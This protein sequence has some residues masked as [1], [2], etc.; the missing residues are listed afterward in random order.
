M[1]RPAARSISARRC[2]AP[3]PTRSR[4]KT[5]S[6][7]WQLA[8]EHINNGDPL[9]KKIAPKVTKGLLGK[10]VNLLVADSAAKPNDAVQEQQT[11]IN[12]NKIVAMTGST[13]IGGR[14]GAQQVRRAREDALSGGDLR[15]QRHHRQGLRALLLPPV[16]LR[17]DR[18]Q[19]DRP[20]AAQDLRQEQEGGVHDAGLHLRPHRHQVGERL[21]DRERRLD[22]GDQPDLAARH[23]GLQPVPDQHRQFRRRVHCQR[24]LGPRRGAVDP[25]GQ[26]VRPHCRR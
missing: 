24:E 20:G 14:G 18:G 2:R 13:S 10:Q 9:I 23:P 8:V 12:Q 6:R 17:R 4:A 21:S 7:A 1:A 3:A 26:A 16:L 5:S 15:L 11:F 19:R 25:A 22:H